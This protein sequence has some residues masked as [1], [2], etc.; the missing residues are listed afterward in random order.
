MG[1]RSLR[2][3]LE[4]GVRQ[5]IRY[6]SQDYGGNAYIIGQDVPQMKIKAGRQRRPGDNNIILSGGQ[7]QN[8]KYWK[9]MFRHPGEKLVSTIPRVQEE[10][11]W[12]KKDSE[13]IS[14][15]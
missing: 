13:I 8:L 15:C 1:Q 5:V 6:H 4:Q 11:K 12:E 2:I 10:R 9:E 7:G 14:K 3:P